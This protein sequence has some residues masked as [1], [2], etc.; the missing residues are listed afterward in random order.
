MTKKDYRR[1]EHSCNCEKLARYIIKPE[2]AKDD[3]KFKD[4]NLA[5]C[6]NCLYG[7]CLPKPLFQGFI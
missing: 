2:W 5:R 6:E 4:D 7:Q 1:C 3:P